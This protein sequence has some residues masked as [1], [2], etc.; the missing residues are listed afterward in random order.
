MLKVKEILSQTPSLVEVKVPENGK[1]VVYG[2]VHGQYYDLLNALTLSDL[3][4]PTNILIFNGDLVDRGSWS[5]EVIMLILAM[6]AT[7]PD[8]VHI[9]RGNHETKSMNK[10][11]GFEGEVR[12]KYT[13]LCFDLF[14]EVFN[15]LPLAHV[16]D[17]KVFICHGG[18]FS[19]DNVTLQDIKNVR[20]TF[21]FLNFLQLM[22]LL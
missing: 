9:S 11:Y 2:D 21:T 13:E 8:Y 18:L 5:V 3:P 20:F 16:I 10:V 12:A 14:L 4:S 6:K 7:F 15:Y 17:N 19:D 1:V 22:N